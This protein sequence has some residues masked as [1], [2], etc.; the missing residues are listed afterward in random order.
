M[1]GL[2]TESLVSEQLLDTA[3]KQFDSSHL[4][5]GVEDSAVA[6]IM[7]NS[8]SGFCSVCVCARM[9]ERVCLCVCVRERDSV[10]LCVNMYSHR[11]GGSICIVFPSFQ[12]KAQYLG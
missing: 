6:H 5:W 8:V 10:C 3:T 7:I 12:L 11:C 9:C 1:F 2:R 4:E